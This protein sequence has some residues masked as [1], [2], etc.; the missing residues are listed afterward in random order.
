MTHLAASG[1]H[2]DQGVGH[3]DLRLLAALQE[4]RMQLPAQLQEEELRAG[5]E[6]AD[7]RVGVR[8]HPG[9][10]HFS[11]E[12]QGFGPPLVLNARRD[13]RIPGDD[14]FLLRQPF[15]KSSS[16]LE[17]AALCVH[18][19]QRIHDKSRRDVPTFDGEAVR[20]GPALEIA[21]RCAGFHQGS[22]SAGVGRDSRRPQRCIQLQGLLLPPFRR[23][24]GAHESIPRE[25]TPPG[26]LVEQLPRGGDAATLPVHEQELGTEKVVGTKQSGGQDAAMDLLALGQRSLGSA[27]LQ[28]C[29]E[30]LLGGHGM[31]IL[32]EQALEGFFQAPRLSQGMRREGPV[33]ATRRQVG[34]L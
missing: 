14:V 1:V 4:G 8:L 23:G 34:G 10:L 6:D 12:S 17:V 31:G 32:P 27:E 13:D 11:E 16:Q 24:V 2:N 28:N 29:R 21:R 18:G 22:E 30:V 25:D 26:H 19:H 9:F 20:L 3:E 15:K 7:G 5:L 33:I